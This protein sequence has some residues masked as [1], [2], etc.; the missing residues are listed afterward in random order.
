MIDLNSSVFKSTWGNVLKQLFKNDLDQSLKQVQ[1]L[2]NLS[3]LPYFT[4]NGAIYSAHTLTP[5][6]QYVSPLPSEYVEL[7]LEYSKKS[8]VVLNEIIRVNQLLGLITRDTKTLQDVRDALP[9]VLIKYLSFGG[10]SRTRE[11]AYTIKDNSMHMA[12]YEKTMNLIYLKDAMNI[13]GG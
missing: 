7:A 2:S 8:S 10:L 4:F 1:H 9:E 6:R 5:T 3:G 13:I 11:E 12:Q